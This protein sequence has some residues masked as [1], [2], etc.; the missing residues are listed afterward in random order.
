MVFEFYFLLSA[1][2]ELSF[3]AS[4]IYYCCF[5]AATVS[6]LEISQELA[7][8]KHL[9]DSEELAIECFAGDSCQK[10][11]AYIETCFHFNN[12]FDRFCKP[13]THPKSIQHPSR[14][15]PQTDAIFK[16]RRQMTFCSLGNR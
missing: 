8:G 15:D 10:Q 16:L 12:D 4:P 3:P 7:Y 5:T 13:K 6:R 11:Q 14:T 9:D 2:E 1:I